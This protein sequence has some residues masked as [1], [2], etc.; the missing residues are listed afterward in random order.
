MDCLVDVNHAISVF[1]YWIF[2]S[3]YKKTPVLNRKS[4]DMI[5]DQCVGEEQV[6]VFETLF[7]AV[8]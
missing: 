5:C 7:T 2:D 4:L 6:Y 8:R 3:S 1:G